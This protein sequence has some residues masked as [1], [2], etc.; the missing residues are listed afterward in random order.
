MFTRPAENIHVVHN[1][2]KWNVLLLLKMLS[3][4]ETTRTLWAT[5]SMISTKGDY[6][7][8]LSSYMA[9]WEW[10][11]LARP[12]FWIRSTDYLEICDNIGIWCDM[13]TDVMLYVRY[14][15][16]CSIV[17]W[18]K[19][20]WLVKVEKIMLNQTVNPGNQQG[21]LHNLSTARENIPN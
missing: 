10:Q 2:L 4:L 7:G 18:K 3:E 5:T 1:P 17:S 12:T 11:R 13:V 19:I 8:F 6:G 16:A 15:I 21:L 9:L 14:R 20:V